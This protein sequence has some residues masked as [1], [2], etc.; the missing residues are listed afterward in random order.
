M[1]RVVPIID[2]DSPPTKP[3]NNVLKFLPSLVGA[4][5]EIGSF[6]TTF[7]RSLAGL[8]VVC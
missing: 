8:R 5:L 3:K 6:S 4:E 7:K 2:P 1:I